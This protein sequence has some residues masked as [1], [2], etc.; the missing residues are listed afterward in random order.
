MSDAIAESEGTAGR[1]L[2]AAIRVFAE[3]GYDKASTREICRLAHANVAAI[4][5]HFGDKAGLYREVLRAGASKLEDPFEPAGLDRSAALLRFYRCLLAP[6]AGS[7]L[8]QRLIRIHIRETLEPAHGPGDPGGRAF[9]PHHRKL[10]AFLAREL[11]VARPD[12]EIE[13]LAFS[14]LGMGAVFYHLRGEIGALEARLV[15]RG[16]ALDVA[17]ARL[18]AYAGALIEA[19]AARRRAAVRGAAA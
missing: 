12:L 17:A 9:F 15:T 14:L 2:D 16:R 10:T 18:A 7:K 5:Y 6:L 4:H 8:H 13:R 11:G 3:R 19:E 1:L